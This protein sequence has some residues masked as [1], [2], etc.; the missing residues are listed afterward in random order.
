MYQITML[1]F[2]YVICCNCHPYAFCVLMGYD[3][4]VGE[5]CHLIKFQNGF[6]YWHWW[7]Q[8]SRKHF[9]RTYILTYPGSNGPFHRDQQSSV[10]QLTN[11][12]LATFFESFRNNR[13]REPWF[14][15]FYSIIITSAFVDILECYSI[16]SNTI[17]CFWQFKSR[18]VSCDCKHNQE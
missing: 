18:L 14:V 10:N 1:N 17:I 16:K 11:Q 15:V 8:L 12:E 13:Q 5:K 3:M 2:I 6:I 7:L 9:T 4:L